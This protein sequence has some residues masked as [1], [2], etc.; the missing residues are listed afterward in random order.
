MLDTLQEWLGSNSTLLRVERHANTTPHILHLLQS[1]TAKASL[2]ATLLTLA[3]T[4]DHYKALHKIDNVRYIDLTCTLDTAPDLD[5]L[6][7]ELT[8]TIV[9]NQCLEQLVIVDSI[10]ILSGLG[11]TNRDIVR[12]VQRVM[13]QCRTIVTM[14]VSAV[15]SESE[16]ELDAHLQCLF[17][18]VAGISTLTT[19]ASTEVDGHLTLY[20]EDC[21][22]RSLYKLSER[23]IKVFPLGVSPGLV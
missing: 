16:Q 10:E 17:T 11:C 23:G 15:C 20:S 13:A 8:S 4:A 9:D 1:H 2:P 22:K 14:R 19:G 5:T 3:N 6:Y 21:D 18:S 12:L 7:N